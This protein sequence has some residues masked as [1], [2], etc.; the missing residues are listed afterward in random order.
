MPTTAD[1]KMLF[2]EM[3]RTLSISSSSEEVKRPV[4]GEAYGEPVQVIKPELL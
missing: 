2:L 1:R 3:Y 4:G